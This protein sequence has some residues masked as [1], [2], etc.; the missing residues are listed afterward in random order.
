M[1]HCGKC[2]ESKC[3]TLFDAHKSRKDGK[4]VYCKEC[5]KAYR[6]ENKEARAAY[7]A[8]WRK[9][10]K[11]TLAVYQAQW[12]QENKDVKKAYQAQYYQEN[13]EA[14]AAQKAQYYQENKEVIAQYKKE[15]KEAYAAYEAKRRAAKLQRTPK[16]LTDD[17]YHEI[18]EVYSSCPEGHHVDHIVPLQGENVSGLHVPWNLQHLT[19]EENIRKG[20][21]LQENHR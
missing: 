20:N 14:V 13:K 3:L 8:Q 16:W 6:E 17:H 11:E 4:Q 5:R 12:Y 7:N 10:N 21:K 18:K 15:N 1:K 9:E 19:A 2:K